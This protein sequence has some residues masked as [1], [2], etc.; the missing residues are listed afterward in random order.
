M[1]TL[2]LVLEPR[3]SV[4]L[5]GTPLGLD[6]ARELLLGPRAAGHAI[7]ALAFIPQGADSIGAIA[8]EIAP[9]TM[10]LGGRLVA[11]IPFEALPGDHQA[12]VRA[13]FARSGASLTVLPGFDWGLPGMENALSA[14]SVPRVEPGPTPPRPQVEGADRTQWIVAIPQ[15]AI[16]QGDRRISARKV[17]SLPTLLGVPVYVA[18]CSAP[19]TSVLAVIDGADGAEV[20]GVL[21][22]DV[23]RASRA[24][25]TLLLVRLEDESE[26]LDQAAFIQSYARN[27]GLG[28]VEVVEL[29]NPG[30]NAIE[31]AV[32]GPFQLVVAPA[33]G[34]ALHGRDLAELVA[35]GDASVM[36]A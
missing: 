34:H 31:R 3:D 17:P 26:P 22:C 27:T 29:V 7:C 36:L 9:L 33:I 32:R 6:R 28:I 30:R 18:A 35:S 5:S 24:H 4:I 11:A 16:G 12:A 8:G 13:Q 1:P 20:A 25:L 14:A 2:D 21:A 10:A 19:P 15:V 23:A